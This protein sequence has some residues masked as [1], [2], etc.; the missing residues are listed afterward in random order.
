[1]FR[2]S[3]ESDIDSRQMGKSRNAK[4]FLGGNMKKLT[5]LLGFSLFLLSCQSNDV[6]PVNTQAAAPNGQVLINGAGASLPNP[7]YSKWFD[8]YHRKFP[9]IQINYQPL[10]SGAGVRQ[11]IE[12]TVDFGASDMPMM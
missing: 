3:M 6:T 10:G 5:F 9:N 2:Q 12:G 7:I 8:E 1:M 11:V 4:S